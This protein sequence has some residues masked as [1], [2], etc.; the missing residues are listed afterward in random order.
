MASR[1]TAASSGKPASRSRSTTSARDLSRGRSLAQPTMNSSAF[2]SRSLSRNG[3]GSIASNN[4][5]S[6]PTCT[7]ITAQLGGIASPAKSFTSA[8]EVFVIKCPAHNQ[9]GRDRYN[10][11]LPFR[12]HSCPKHRTGR[13]D[14]K[15]ERLGRAHSRTSQTNDTQGPPTACDSPSPVASGR[16]RENSVPPRVC[17]WATHNVQV[18]VPTRCF[19]ID[20]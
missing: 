3:E 16:N 6:S 7:S 2:G 17:I 10:H 9:L 4:C 1:R 11:H 15:D 8:L 14:R 13:A 5:F 12:L 18:N 20:Q 19:V